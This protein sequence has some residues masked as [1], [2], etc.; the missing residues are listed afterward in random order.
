MASDFLMVTN[1]FELNVLFSH[2]YAVLNT[3]LYHRVGWLSLVPL[4]SESHS[5]F[6]KLD[7]PLSARFMSDLVHFLFHQLK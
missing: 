7:K 1:H 5:I 6:V 2:A 3:L 4:T